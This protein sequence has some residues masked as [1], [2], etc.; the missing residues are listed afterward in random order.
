MKIVINIDMI[1]ELNKFVK[2]DQK[3]KYCQ[4]EN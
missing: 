4:E 2:K 1:M 3:L